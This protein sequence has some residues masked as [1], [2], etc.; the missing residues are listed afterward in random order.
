MFL[1]KL[2]RQLCVRKLFALRISRVV[3]ATFGLDSLA[4]EHIYYDVRLGFVRLAVDHREEPVP[5]SVYNVRQCSAH[6]QRTLQ[7]RTEY[8]PPLAKFTLIT[9][10]N[11]AP[12]NAVY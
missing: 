9:D 8:A 1:N 7:N 4:S 6:A 10:I 12:R 3:A 11:H 2:P 5:P